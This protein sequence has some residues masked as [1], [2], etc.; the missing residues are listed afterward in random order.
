MIFSSLC[1]DVQ[2]HISLSVHTDY[3]LP[4]CILTFLSKTFFQVLC[5]PCGHD[6]IGF[7]RWNLYPSNNRISRP[8]HTF[9]GTVQL[10]V[11]WGRR[12]TSIIF[13]DVEQLPKEDYF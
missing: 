8:V 3:T 11:L 6:H 7:H 1:L 4:L 12:L 2:I 13:Y 5:G 10:M 9:V